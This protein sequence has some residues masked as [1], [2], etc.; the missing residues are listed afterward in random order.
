MYFVRLD[1]R[2]ID[3]FIGLRS[4]QTIRL[5]GFNAGKDYPDALRRICFVDQET[6]KKLFFLTNN[7]MLPAHL[8][9]QLYKSR[10]WVELFF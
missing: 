1:Y 8:I 6:K 5:R 7:L 2:P 3:K 4:D 9:P 10:W